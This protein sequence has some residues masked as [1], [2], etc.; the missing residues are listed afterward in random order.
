MSVVDDVLIGH[1]QEVRRGSVVIA[2]LAALRRPRHG[3]GL[4]SDLAA[5]GIE[6]GGDT[7]YPLLRRLERQ[8]LLRSTWNTDEARPRKSYITTPVGEQVLQSLLDEWNA[9]TVAIGAVVSQQ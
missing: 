7:L 9:L 5:A 1:V 8:G 3:Y 6:V 4:I 2:C